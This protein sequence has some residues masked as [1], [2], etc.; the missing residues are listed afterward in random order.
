MLTIK[1]VWKINF[2]LIFISIVFLLCFLT[3]KYISNDKFELDQKPE[4]G[5]RIMSKLGNQFFSFDQN[6]NLW[7]PE[8][9]RWKNKD[10]KYYADFWN[11]KSSEVKEM[12]SKKIKPNED[13]KNKA[14]IHFRC[15]DSPFNRLGG[16]YLMK[17]EYYSEVAKILEK[18]DIDEIYFMNCSHWGK[19]F[20]GIN[21]TE[22]YCN[23]YIET[24]TEWLK[25]LTDI[26]INSNKIC[27]NIFDSYSIMWGAKI[28]VSTGGS[29]SFVPGVLKGKKFIT[30][31]NLTSTEK[32]RVKNLKDQVHWKMV[33][34]FNHIE[35]GKIKDYATFDY[36]NYNKL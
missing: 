31:R 30:P 11:K 4:I 36:K 25:E 7:E 10:S 23:D 8:G 14:V 32:K 35:H 29:F 12:L 15:S 27:T 21:N 24:I 33:E 22:V 5:N 6:R 3:Y 19:S 26:K 17:K 34:D 2:I 16:Y 13:F 28:L 20:G 9:Y 1:Y 18:E